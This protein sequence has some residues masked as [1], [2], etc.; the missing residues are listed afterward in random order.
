MSLNRFS[1][2]PDEFGLYTTI[3]S[4]GEQVP[5]ANLNYSDFDN[6]KIICKQYALV[7]RLGGKNVADKFFRRLPIAELQTS[8]NSFSNDEFID[9]LKK[10]KRLLPTYRKLKREL[11]WIQIAF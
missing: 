9:I 4:N 8:Y 7:G 1:T 2:T 6:V 5:T 10:V 11:K 3:F